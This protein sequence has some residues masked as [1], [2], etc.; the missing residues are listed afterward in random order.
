MSLHIKEFS[1][2]TKVKTLLFLQK[3]YL[4]ISAVFFLF[5][6]LITPLDIFN[7]NIPL[8]IQ[9]GFYSIVRFDI[10]GDDGARYVPLRSI[11]FDNDIDFINEP[12]TK[13]GG[14]NDKTGNFNSFWPI[15][16]SILWFPF[17]IVGHIFALL[18]KSLGFDISIDGYSFPYITMISLGSACYGYLGTLFCYKSLCDSFDK[19]ISSADY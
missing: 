9:E 16:S 11:F 13:M 17:F 18:I 7:S 10:S 4:I 14:I 2:Y 19:K 8:Q 3:E 5:F 6:L 15:G 12:F 1:Y